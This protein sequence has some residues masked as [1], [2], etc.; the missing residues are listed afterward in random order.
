M[1]ADEV[2][3]AGGCGCGSGGCCGSGGKRKPVTGVAR[4]LAFLAIVMA[5]A[6]LVVKGLAQP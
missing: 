5:A 3:E 2:K 4:F 1:G 6:F